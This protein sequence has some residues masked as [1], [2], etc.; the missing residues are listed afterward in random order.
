[1][2]LP[3]SDRIARAPGA[4]KRLALRLLFSIP[5]AIVE[6]VLTLGVSIFFVTG[7]VLL[8]VYGYS[9]GWFAAVAS[10]LFAAFF[11]WFVTD[12][13]DVDLNHRPLP[14]ATQRRIDRMVPDWVLDDEDRARMRLADEEQQADPQWHRNLRFALS[15]IAGVLL[16]LGAHHG[17]G[18]PVFFSLAITLVA[19]MGFHRLFKPG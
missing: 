12:F 4:L 3:D 1:M 2:P 15:W 8:M 5:A 11:L 10:A 14:L 18:V 6:L 7:T 9:M 17:A 19:G 13:F 16:G